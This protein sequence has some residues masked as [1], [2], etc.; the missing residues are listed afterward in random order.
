M[1]TPL[2][3]TGRLTEAA[4]GQEAPRPVR[5]PV[6][7]FTLI[8]LVAVMTVLSILALALVVGTGAGSLM[9]RDRD[10]AAGS[11]ARSLESAVSTARARAFHT[12]V[13]HGLLPQPEGWQMLVRDRD[14]GGWRG[15]GAGRATGLTWI[16][17]G[18][19][20]FPTPPLADTSPRPLVV[21]ASDGRATPFTVDFHAAP[22]GF[23]CTT[24]GWEVLQCARR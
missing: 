12:R 17:D 18:T 4:P 16:I 15:A 8:E 6:P 10:S 2:S 14:A 13:P 3:E 21:F 22:D 1:S 24:D 19:A 20:H 9:G 7:G 5:P 23:R 11:A